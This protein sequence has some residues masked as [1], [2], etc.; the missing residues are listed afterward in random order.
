MQFIP[1]IFEFLKFFVKRKVALSSVILAAIWFVG[2]KYFNVED[3]TT[4]SV[5]NTILGLDINI[6]LKAVFTI[7]SIIIF[8]GLLV[9]IFI[10]KD[11]RRINKLKIRLEEEQIET[12]ILKH[13]L[14]Q[15]ELKEKLNEKLND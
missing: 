1:I 2:A 15:K 9:W 8:V 4:I 10:S 5:M 14:Q 12:E 11:K 13:D 3:N 6:D 7:L